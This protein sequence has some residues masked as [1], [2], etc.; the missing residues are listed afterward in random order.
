MP[1][2][3]LPAHKRKEFM[4]WTYVIGCS[5]L[6]GIGVV[7]ATTAKQCLTLYRTKKQVHQCQT[8]QPI[9]ADTMH[10]NIV[11]LTERKKRIEKLL[12]K[13]N[14]FTILQQVVKALPTKTTLTQFSLSK[15]QLEIS[16]I[17]TDPTE[18]S[19]LL[20]NLKK[21]SLLQ[22]IVVTSLSQ[23][24]LAGEDERLNF[25]LKADILEE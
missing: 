3:Q 14:R 2:A 17:L 22:Q 15:K 18:L 8:A 20:N 23:S 12:K 16:G 11:M 24:R 1:F 19:E 13:K 25:S 5:W 10:Q 6:I 4:R 21:I 7:L 9:V